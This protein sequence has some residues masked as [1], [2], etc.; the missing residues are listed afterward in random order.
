MAV[1]E[2]AIAAY[3]ERIREIAENIKASYNTPFALNEVMSP[4]TTMKV[5]GAALAFAAP[6]DTASLTVLLAGCIASGVPF[7]IIGGGSNIIVSDEGFRGVMISTGGLDTIEDA[8]EHVVCGAGVRMSHVV[9]WFSSHGISGMEKFS[10]LPGTCGGA[11]YMNARCYGLDTCSAL[12]FA[13]YIDLD[14]LASAVR[15]RGSAGAFSRDDVDALISL[16]SKRLAVRESSAGSPDSPWGYKKSPFMKMKSVITRVAF[17]AGARDAGR[18]EALRAECRRYMQDR[19][20]KGHF[21]APCAGSVFKNNPAHG[22]PAGRIIDEAGLRGL[23]EGGA[24]VAPWHG[25]IIINTGGAT[26]RDIRALV[27]RVRRR[28]KEAKGFD[29]ECEIIFVPYQ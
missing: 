9:D 12:D 24:Q 8:G 19:T 29:L 5:G 16:S 27:E 14:S 23:R 18:A 13:G 6:R 1:R 20:D 15:E 17:K 28:V 22:A 26:C 25:N 3:A 10:G 4:H 11:V 2:A 21:R 7:Y